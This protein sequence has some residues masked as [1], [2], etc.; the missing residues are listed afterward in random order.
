MGRLLLIPLLAAA[1]GKST[2]QAPITD[3]RREYCSLL[4][5]CALTAPD[6][7]CTAET[8]KPMDGVKYD[9]G[10]CADAREL[11]THGL[12]TQDLDGYPVYR[13][14]GKRYRVTYLVEGQ[15][16]MSPARLSF[17]IDDL[18]LAAKLLSRLG[19]SRYTAEY[20]DETRRRFRGSKADTLTGDAAIVAGGTKEGWLAYFGRGKSK[21]GFWKLGGQSYARIRYDAVPAP[22][23]GL[24]YSLQVV[25]TP[26]SSV[27]NRIMTLG[28]FRRIVHGHIREVVDDIDRASRKLS[29]I[30]S[31]GLKDGWT[32]EERKQVD[33]FLALP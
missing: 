9:D 12:L 14:L 11:H 16:P 20:V 8:G 6:G 5:A 29:E 19:N 1:V 26:D 21:V 24:S 7:A 28:L 31:A 18:P 3:L 23:R 4:T 10:R 27:A 15:L 22:G 25:V 30:G 2:E 17:L 32:A 33:A 13:F